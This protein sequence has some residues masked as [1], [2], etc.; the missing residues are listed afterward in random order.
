M[1][2]KIGRPS[3][4]QQVSCA[5]CGG[6]VT[7][8]PSEIARSTTGRF[9]CSPQCRNK[10]GS[11]PRTGSY[12]PCEWCG[13]DFWVVKSQDATARFCSRECRDL[14][15]RVGTEVR[16][17]A[18]CGNKF[19]FNLKMRK[20]NT[21]Q[22]CTRECYDKHRLTQSVGRKKYTTDGYVVVKT[23]DRGWVPEHRL[24][25][26]DE[27]DRYL[28]PNENVHHANGVRDDNRIENLELWTTS[29]PSGQRVT[30]VVG[31]ATE[32]LA[33]YA[34]ELLKEG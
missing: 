30:D 7:K 6:Q 14:G 31:W 34:P 5:N 2:T 28:L 22:F 29:Q 25:M 18:G 32:V 19:E 10:V 17:C 11:K 9:F 33:R 4:A 27:L 21:G 1:T 15:N 3:T 24:V 12:K 20:W 23:E 13:T 8:R 16:E 26:E